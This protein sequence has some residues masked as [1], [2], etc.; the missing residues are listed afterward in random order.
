MLSVINSGA[1]LLL[2][3]NNNNSTKHVTCKDLKLLL[4]YE[5]LIYS[6]RKWKEWG[7]E[8]RDLFEKGIKH[9]SEESKAATC[10]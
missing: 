8:E 4:K 7:V 10:I 2:I 5:S 9:Q 3:I 6:H 1:T